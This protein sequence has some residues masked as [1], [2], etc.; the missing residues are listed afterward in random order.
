MEYCP[1]I[2]NT[3]DGD[4]ARGNKQ[5]LTKLAAQLYNQASVPK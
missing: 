2:G 1:I 3:L 5:V 4:T